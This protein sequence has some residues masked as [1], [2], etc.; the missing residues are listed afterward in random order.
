MHF[1]VWLVILLLV[2]MMT[3]LII[4]AFFLITGESSQSLLN[5]ITFSSIDTSFGNGILAD[6]VWDSTSPNYQKAVLAKVQSLRTFLALAEW[7]RF[8]PPITDPSLPYY[9]Q[10]PESAISVKTYLAGQ[11]GIPYQGSENNL[12]GY[13]LTPTQVGLNFAT[14]M[15]PSGRVFNGHDVLGGVREIGIIIIYAVA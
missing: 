12:I 9:F 15:V 10:L 11:S 7:V 3:G 4:G 13:L 5:E 8:T 6:T 2:I 1:F 14:G